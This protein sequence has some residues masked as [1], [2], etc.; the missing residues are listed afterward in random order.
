MYSPDITQASNFVKGVDTAFLLILGISFFFLIALTVVMIYF[1]YKYNK[2]RHPVATQI[3]GSTT[4]EIVWTVIPFI[5]TM[6]MFYYGWA[7]WK[8]MQKAPE[9]AMEI[10]V[11]GRMWNFSYEYENGRRTDTLFVPKDQAV[12]LNLKA[13]DVVHS[14]YIPAFRVKQD[15]VPEKKNNFMWFIPQRVGNFEVYCTEYCGL[16]HSYMLSTV[17]VMEN[18]DFQKWI[19]DTTQVAA[20]ANIDAPGAT[21]KRIMQNIGCFACHTVDGTKLVGPSFKGIWGEEQT[22]VTGGATRKIKV[23]EEYIK[24]SIYDPNADVVEGFTKGLMV[25]YQSQLSDD[26]I[27]NIIEYLKTVK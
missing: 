1:I 17:K 26:D 7:G 24:R 10:T 15:M 21:G 5:L 12:K 4:L 11:Y 6:V 3:H 20:V 2:K 16:Q 13:M 25:S 19:T 14:F 18:N 22:V 23:D 27:A 8:P 9:D